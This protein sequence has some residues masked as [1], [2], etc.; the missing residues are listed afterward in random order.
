MKEQPGCI[1]TEVINLVLEVMKVTLTQIVRT[2]G[3]V[4]QDPPIAGLEEEMET[5]DQ[6]VDMGEVVAEEVE[7]EGEVVEEAGEV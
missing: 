4:L 6:T 2:L 7:E 3:E 1:L 5:L